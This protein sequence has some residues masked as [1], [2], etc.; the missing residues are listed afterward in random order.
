M[1]DI[2]LEIG[3]FLG[4]VDLNGVEAIQTEQVQELEEYVRRCNEAHNEGKDLVADAVYDKLMEIL[5]RVSPESELCK[6]IW[7]DSTDEVDSDTDSV[8]IKN[9]MYS[10]MTVKSFDCDEIKL[11]VSRLGDENFDAHVS[12]KLNGHG[13]RLI[14]KDGMFVQARSRARASAGRDLTDQLIPVL[15]ELDL[16]ELPDCAGIPILE[17]RGEWVMPFANM[18]EARAINPDIKSAFTAV[19]AI[20]KGSGTPEEWGLLHFVAYEFLAEGIT[21]DTKTAEY[22]YLEELGFEIPL[23][24]EIP[25]LNK[26]TLIEELKT[27]VADCEEQVKPNADGTGG[28]DYYTDGLVFSIN[29]IRSFKELGDDGSHYKFG[30]MALKVGYWKQDMYMGIVQTIAWMPGKSGLSPVAIIA[31]EADLIEF[32]DNEFHAYVTDLKEIANMNA[33]GVITAG[34]NKVRRVPLYDS[35][36]LVHLNAYYGEPIYFRYGGEAG[37]VPCFEDGTPLLEGKARKVISGDTDDDDDWFPT[38]IDTAEYD[39]N[40]EYFS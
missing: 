34:G 13:I 3:D 1:A 17:I 15:Q 29:D 39:P 40:A 27:I 19:S 38:E 23:Y 25:D 28:Y 10:I 20:G 9:P 26:A 22:S 31:E 21:F 11:F 4:F 12:V 35:A 2:K 16:L 37:V 5:R 6:Y 30:N 7:E 8:F 18:P 24:W 33:L 32:T 14:Y 36:N